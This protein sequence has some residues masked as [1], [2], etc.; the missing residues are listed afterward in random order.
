MGTSIPSQ[1]LA[2]MDSRTGRN[3]LEWYTAL[4]RLAK[5]VDPLYLTLNKD[6]FAAVFDPPDSFGG[7]V[8]RVVGT[9]ASAGYHAALAFMPGGAD[10]RIG[11]YGF[12]A[13]NGSA[14]SGVAF[15]RNAANITAFSEAAWT[16][17]VSHPCN[18]RFEVTASGSATR[19]ER[20]RVD[21]TGFYILNGVAIP[22]GGTAAT[23]YRFS[24]T[25]NFGMFFGSGAPALSAA[26]GSLYLRS[27]GA[28]IGSR[29]YINTDGGTTWTSITTAA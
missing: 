21:S 19:G 6:G 11:F 27:D 8:V 28:G 13:F 20:A 22:A 16:D 18:I 3:N 24:S 23:G 26:K 7:N 17:G 4:G 29:A 12:A 5:G 9:S 14:N 25:A 10:V 2:F 15:A 1:D